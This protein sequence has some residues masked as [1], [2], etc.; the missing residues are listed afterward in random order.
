MIDKRV[1]SNLDCLSVVE[2]N[3]EIEKSVTDDGG[4]QGIDQG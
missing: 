3:L 4:D 1:A 2:S